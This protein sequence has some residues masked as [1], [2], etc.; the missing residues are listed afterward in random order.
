MHSVELE[1]VFCFALLSTKL[2]PHCSEKYVEYDSM[3]VDD[4]NDGGDTICGETTTK[5]LT[6]L[7]I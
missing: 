4:K 5:Y 2:T 1:L 3:F 6:L 7:C